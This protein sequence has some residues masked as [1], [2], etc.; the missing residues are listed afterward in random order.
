M[1]TFK[2]IVLALVVAAAAAILLKVFAHGLGRPGRLQAFAEARGGTYS[3]HDDFDLKP[4]LDNLFDGDAY[5]GRA[6]TL[7]DPDRDDRLYLVEL[8]SEPAASPNRTAVL[9]SVDR[10]DEALCW[11]RQCAPLTLRARLPTST[12]T[13]DAD[14][15]D[16]FDVDTDPDPPIELL[17]LLDRRT[18]D[19]EWLPELRLRGD[20]MAVLTRDRLLADDDE[21]EQLIELARILRRRL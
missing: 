11:P 3:A 2:F 15:R 16:R 18:G 7:D 4:A 12:D 14:I 9:L 5:P 17:K 21:W 6:A 19:L 1:A 10:P 8:H 20:Q 13:E